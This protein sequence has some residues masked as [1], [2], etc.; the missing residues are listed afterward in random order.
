MSDRYT[1][2]LTADSVR[3]AL[4]V[5]HVETERTMVVSTAHLPPVMPD[6][7]ARAGLVAVYDGGWIVCVDVCTE[8]LLA[9]APE[10]GGLFALAAVNG[11]RWVRFDRDAETV[12]GYKK[13]NW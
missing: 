11:C 4:E 8:T 7:L 12:P 2:H 1:A 6:V 10:L 3:L 13:F 5:P 9:A